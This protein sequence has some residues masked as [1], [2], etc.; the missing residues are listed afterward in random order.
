[1]KALLK[2]KRRSPKRSPFAKRDGLERLDVLSL[3]AFGALGHVELHGLALLQALETAC[4]NRR[5]MYENVFAGLAADKAVAFGVIEPLY[6]SLF[7]HGARCSFRL[8]ILRW[9]E[10]GGDRCRIL[11]VEAS[12]AHDRLGLTHKVMVRVGEGISKGI[13]GRL[14]VVGLM[15]RSAGR[16]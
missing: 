8:S 16:Q 10:I 12:A 6:C 1:M 2:Q 14:S 7:C 9:R 5:E 15:A 13:L 11:A 3:P 4:L